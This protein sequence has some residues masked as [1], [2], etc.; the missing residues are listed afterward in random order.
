MWYLLALS[1]KLTNSQHTAT[2]LAFKNS[3]TSIYPWV[4]AALC[5]T[6]ASEYIDKKIRYHETRRAL[7]K[8]QNIDE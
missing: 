8:N 5:Y 1:I 4:L 7:K 2:P 6:K 3:F